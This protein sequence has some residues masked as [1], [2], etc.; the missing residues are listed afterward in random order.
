MEEKCICETGDEMS[1]EFGKWPRISVYRNEYDG[2]WY[3]GIDYDDYEAGGEY[4]PIYHC[5]ICGKEL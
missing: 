1:S 4:G 5:P 2:A 3:V